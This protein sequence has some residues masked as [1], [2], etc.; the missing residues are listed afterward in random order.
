MQVAFRACQL[1]KLKLTL[2]TK[3]PDV[4]WRLPHLFNVLI[5]L[6]TNSTREGGVGLEYLQLSG[7]KPEVRWY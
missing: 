3:T 1:L 2:K 6:L 4:R 7:G 5:H